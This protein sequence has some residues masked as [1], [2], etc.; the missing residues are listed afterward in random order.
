MCRELA[1]QQ[2]LV[3]ATDSGV[4]VPELNLRVMERSGLVIC[5]DCQPE[6]LWQRIGQSDDRPMLAA[7]DEGRFARL[8]TL[9]EQRA[10]AY[11]RI[12]HHIEVTHLLPQEVAE[13]VCAYL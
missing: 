10:P 9:L 11:A 6:R 13:Q 8:Q 2:A 12:A 7:Q 1:G 3:I 5:L 4:L